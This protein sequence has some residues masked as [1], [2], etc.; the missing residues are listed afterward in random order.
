MKVDR[1]K[2]GEAGRALQ[3]TTALFVLAPLHRRAL[4][5]VEADEDGVA[6]VLA[7]LTHRHDWLSYVEM[8]VP[9]R[10]QRRS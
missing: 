2:G 8:G 10:R 1:A 3:H 7:G 9:A 4:R 5:A 6:D